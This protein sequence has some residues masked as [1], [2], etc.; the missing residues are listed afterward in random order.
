MG[1][2]LTLLL[3]QSAVEGKVGQNSKS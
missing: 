1:I 3:A 2:K